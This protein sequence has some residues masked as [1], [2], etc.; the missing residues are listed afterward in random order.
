[1]GVLCIS[2]SISISVSIQIEFANFYPLFLEQH[3]VVPYNHLIGIE[4]GPSLHES[5]EYRIKYRNYNSNYNILL[6]E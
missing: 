2:I 3:N 1:M 4:M 5:Y 6:L